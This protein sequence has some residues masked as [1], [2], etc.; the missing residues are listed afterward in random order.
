MK[1]NRITIIGTFN[2]NDTVTF[3]ATE[4]IFTG[5]GASEYTDTLIEAGKTEEVLYDEESD[6]DLTEEFFEKKYGK[7]GYD[8]WCAIQ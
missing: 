2:A 8:F 7:D 5:E 4:T 6:A 1:N 3:K